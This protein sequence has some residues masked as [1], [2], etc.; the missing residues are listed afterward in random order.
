MKE[1]K[2]HWLTGSIFNLNTFELNWVYHP[3][4]I[5]ALANMN[6]FYFNPNVSF[7]CLTTANTLFPLST[8]W[9]WLQISRQQFD[10]IMDLIES[11]K[12]EG[13]RLEYGGSAVGEKTLYIQPT[14]FSGVKD[15]M[16]IAKEEV[17][18]L[19]QFTADGSDTGM[20]VCGS[21]AWH[22]VD[23]LFN[24]TVDIQLRG[25]GYAGEVC[26]EEIKTKF[27]F[28]GGFSTS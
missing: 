28:Y 9:C 26:E 1:S 10:K 24:Y 15:H 4:A 16:R 2:T 5:S 3:G 22:P 18:N 23:K 8:V 27:Y 19:F 17:Y 7:D 12:E 14:I 13:A 20:E 25:A 11:G 6:S 21:K